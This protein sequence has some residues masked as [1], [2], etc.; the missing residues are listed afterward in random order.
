M[1]IQNFEALQ[2]YMNTENEHWNNWMCELTTE[3]I[4]GG[5]FNDIEQALQLFN[6][7]LE[8]AL[9][10]PKQPLKALL[11][12]QKEFE[13]KSLTTKQALF[14]WGFLT[15]YIRNSEFENTD[16][17]DFNELAINYAARIRKEVN[18]QGEAPILQGMKEQ[19]AELLNNEL[20]KVP[21][22]L[23]QLEPEKRLAVLCKLLPYVIPRFDVTTEIKKDAF[24]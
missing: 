16:L 19:L 10:K 3:A 17:T 11:E 24:D 12:I 23:E 2:G 14:V 8:A 20:Q 9:A 4:K 7:A 1:N 6:F 21:L 13:A 15:K 18:Q 22:M 5:Q